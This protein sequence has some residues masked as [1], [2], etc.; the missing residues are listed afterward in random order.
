MKANGALN[1]IMTGSGSTVFGLYATEEKARKAV[2][3]LTGLGEIFVAAPVPA[4]SL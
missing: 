4:V 1:A 2:S 3:S